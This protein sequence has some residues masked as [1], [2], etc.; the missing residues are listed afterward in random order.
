LAWADSIKIFRNRQ[1]IRTGVV[2]L[3]E[4]GANN[5]TTI[6]NYI[7]NAY[8]TWSIPPA[9][10]LIMADYGTGSVTGNGITSPIYNNYCVS[11]N[12]YGD[13]NSNSKPDIAMARMTAENATHLQTMVTKF[14]DYERTPPNNPNFY[15]N[16]ITALGW[17]TERWFQIC[18]ET[19]GGFWNNE[20]GKSTVRINEIYSGT[21]GSVWSTNQ[22]TY[23]VVDYFGPNGTNYIPAAPSS[24][25]G[26]SGGK[27]KAAHSCFNTV[28]MAM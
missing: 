6:E 15:Q 23:M 18:S 14:L 13:V 8:N 1:G 10:I 12:I 21:P 20:M 2:T 3:A 11:D 27:F 19:V 4:I 28:T 26:W 17:Q 16:P 7:N 5:A 22:N 9:A 24:L 25:G